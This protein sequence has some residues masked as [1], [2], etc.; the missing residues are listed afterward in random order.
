MRSQTTNH[1]K[2]TAS[3]AYST[4]SSMFRWMPARCTSRSTFYAFAIVI[5]NSWTWQMTSISS[6]WS[7]GCLWYMGTRW[8]KTCCSCRIGFIPPY[9]N[10]EKPSHQ[11]SSSSFRGLHLWCLRPRRSSKAS[12]FSPPSTSSRST[13]WTS[14]PVWIV[15][16]SWMESRKG[17]SVREWRQM[18]HCTRRIRIRGLRT[19]KLMN[20]NNWEW[21]LKR[22]S[23]NLI[24]HPLNKVLDLCH[25]H[26]N[27]E[28][29]NVFKR[30][31]K[32][33]K[34]CDSQTN[35]ALTPGVKHYLTRLWGRRNPWYSK[36][37]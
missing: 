36:I 31:R 37:W 11:V 13:P 25:I 23:I 6:T 16:G 7:W 33:I 10:L 5:Y 2:S 1:A 17:N 21:K 4:W 18:I 30:S 34:N 19:W 32:S 26:P 29:A 20:K 15:I 22:K 27:R 9:R 24:S 3:S 8:F 12:W 28:W 14:M 35:L